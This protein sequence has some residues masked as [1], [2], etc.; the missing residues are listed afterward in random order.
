[1]ITIPASVTSIGRIAF[2]NCK[3][4][5]EINVAPGNTAYHAEENCLIETGS[6]TLIKG[7]NDSVI[8]TDG[9]VTSI[10]EY[11][12]KDCT[13][14]TSISLPDSITSIGASAFYGCKNMT[15]I[16]IPDSLTSIGSEAFNGC[17][18]L[19]SITIPDG[20]T[21]I[22]GS[23][24]KYC[25]KLASISIPCSVTSIG[26]SAFWNCFSLISINYVGTVEQ[27]K[28]DILFGKSWNEG[29]RNYII[30]CSDGTIAKDGTVTMS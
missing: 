23:T 1:M 20:V 8:P 24:F 7:F 15:S 25:N 2:N 17:T 28:N 6:K 12:F 21:A 26:N 19:T 10:G 4:L 14:L 13:G 30:Y 27:W 29:A 5:T 22:Y 16:T 18:S 9:S 3:N 11:A